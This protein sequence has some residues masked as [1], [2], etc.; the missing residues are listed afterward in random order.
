[1]D[2]IAAAVRVGWRTGR[3]CSRSVGVGR[4]D[5]C[6]RPSGGPVGLLAESVVAAT[7]LRGPMGTRRPRGGRPPP[8]TG[9]R[10]QPMRGGSRR[11][12]AGRSTV[13]AVRG[14]CSKDCPRGRVGARSR[15]RDRLSD[16]GVTP[17]VSGRWWRMRGPHRQRRADPRVATRTRRGV[18]PGE[19]WGRPRTGARVTGRVLVGVLP[20]SP[21]MSPSRPIPTP[22]RRVALPRGGHH[23]G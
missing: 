18:Q 1:M 23:G 21:R 19:V 3:S 2:R 7:A 16:I 20:P 14:A 17:G 22:P 12:R 13:S 9:F 8:R 15:A 5:K 10:R 4:A 11:P 6:G